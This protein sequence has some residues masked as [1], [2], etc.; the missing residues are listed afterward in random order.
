[1]KEGKAA[2]ATAAFPFGVK[3]RCQFWCVVIISHIYVCVCIVYI[4]I[5]I[6]VCVCLYVHVIHIM[7]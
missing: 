7:L 6:C 3:N 2:L 4:Y 1:M 5:A